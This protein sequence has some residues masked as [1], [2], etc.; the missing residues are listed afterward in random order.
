MLRI[1][2][3]GSP[4]ENNGT[5]QNVQLYVFDFCAASPNF[6]FRHDF[7]ADTW[8]PS[9]NGKFGSLYLSVAKFCNYTNTPYCQNPSV[10]TVSLQTDASGNETA[11]VS[12]LTNQCRRSISGS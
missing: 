10:Y 2:E 5:S 8:G 11:G 4:F 1:Y 7:I 3:V 6:A 9:G 12:Q